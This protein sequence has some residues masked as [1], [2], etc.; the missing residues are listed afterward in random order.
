MEVLQ[1][2]CKPQAYT[3]QK[4]KYPTS[5]SYGR[6]FKKKGYRVQGSSAHLC[7]WIPYRELTR[8]RSNNPTHI[9]VHWKISPTELFS[10]EDWTGSNSWI[11]KGGRKYA[12][13]FQQSSNLF[14]SSHCLQVNKNLNLEHKG[15]WFVGAK[16]SLILYLR[17]T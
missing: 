7:W 1:T 13:P 9:S 4:G 12:F 2:K 10:F 6:S 14:G 8:C 15:N 11:A 3:R 17:L 16:R 5:T